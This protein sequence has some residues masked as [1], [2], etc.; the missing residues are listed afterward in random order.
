M[1]LKYLFYHVPYESPKVSGYD[2]CCLVIAE[3]LKE[4]GDTFY[5]NINFWKEYGDNEY[6]VKQ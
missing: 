2:H 4:L 6:T 1:A 3:G 5:G